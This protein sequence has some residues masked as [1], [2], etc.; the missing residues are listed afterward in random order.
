MAKLFNAKY[1]LVI[2]LVFIVGFLL[3]IIIDNKDHI[4]NS[5]FL[6]FGPHKDEYGEYQTLIGIKLNTW[7]AIIS[8]YFIIFF[9]ALFQNYYNVSLKSNLLNYVYSISTNYIPYGKT[10]GNIL[11]YIYPLILFIFDIIKIMSIVSYQ[12]QFIIPQLL[13]IYAVHIPYTYSIIKNMI[14]TA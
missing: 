9:A 7:N 1:S 14:F 2:A 5:Y 3:F 11:L 4:K 8:V 6:R 13:G 12:L 10:T